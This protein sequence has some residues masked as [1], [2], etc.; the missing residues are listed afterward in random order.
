MR[1]WANEGFL[2]GELG[3][4]LKTRAT[5][6]APR[7]Q[8]LPFLGW[9][10]LRRTRGRIR[11]RLWLYRTGQWSQQRMVNA[12]SSVIAHLKQGNPRRLRDEWLRRWLDFQ[13]E[14]RDGSRHRRSRQPR[15]RLEQHRD[16]RPFVEPELQ[17]SVEPQPRSRCSSR[18]GVAMPDRVPPSRSIVKDSRA[19][20]VIPRSVSGAG[21]P[22]E[23]RSTA[24]VW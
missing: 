5:I 1:H 4:C 21:P 12:V 7:S 16:Q 24:R 2:G 11:H 17:R 20:P 6:L 14:C 23:P 8:G 18:E 19:V 15:G 10:L 3:L 9:R 22:A 13:T